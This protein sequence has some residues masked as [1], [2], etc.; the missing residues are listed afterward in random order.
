MS[1]IWEN[2]FYHLGIVRYCS[3]FC[4]NYILQFVTFELNTWTFF[5]NFSLE[6]NIL[7][8]F[9]SQIQFSRCCRHSSSPGPGCCPIFLHSSDTEGD[10]KAFTY[11]APSQPPRKWNSTLKPTGNSTHNNYF[12]TLFFQEY[13]IGVVS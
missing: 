12:S 10:Q 5:Y 1:G 4:V 8:L 6:T 7:V 2:V 11:C 9:L 3:L 13:V